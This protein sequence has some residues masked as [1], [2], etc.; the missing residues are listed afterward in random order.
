MINWIDFF[1][2]QTVNSPVKNIFPVLNFISVLILITLISIATEIRVPTDYQDNVEEDVGLISHAPKNQK[3]L[4]QYRT[5][6]LIKVNHSTDPSSPFF[7]N[8]RNSFTP[9]QVAQVDHQPDHPSKNLKVDAKLIFNGA[10]VCKEC[11]EREFNIWQRTRH[12]TSFRTAH[13][14]PGD[15][16]KPSP[17]RILKAVG[18]ARRMKK[19]KTCILCHYTMVQEHAAA[20]P[21]AKSGTSCESC[22]GASSEWLTLHDNYGGEGINRMNETPAHKEL[23]IKK[24]AEAGLIWPDRKYQVAE[25]CMTCHGLAHPDLTGDV[26]A[27]MLGAGHPIN[28]DFEVLK[29]SQGTLRHRYTPEEPETNKV[30]TEAEKAELFVIGHAAALVSAKQAMSKSN[31]SKYTHA[32]NKRAEN[33]KAV[34]ELIKDIPEAKYLMASASRGNALKLANTIGGMDLSG[35]LGSKLPAEPVYK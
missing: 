18:G 10:K 32:Q 31:E 34:L 13:R 3:L 4:F 14:E 26:L 33:A 29:Y 8:E 22:H 2:N 21:M 15:S 24:S 9:L 1:A 5:L 25:N 11:H 16:A 35:K 27:K 17:K 23:R 19:N 7:I 28:P 20:K 6:G 30:M 12:Y